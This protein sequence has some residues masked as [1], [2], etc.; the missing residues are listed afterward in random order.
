M[1]QTLSRPSAFIFP[2][3]LHDG[4][5]DA[6]AHARAQGACQ[7][8]PI[9]L[10]LIR[11]HLAENLCRGTCTLVRLACSVGGGK[12]EESESERERAGTEEGETRERGSEGE[13]VGYLRRVASAEAGSSQFR[14]DVSL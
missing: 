5:N 6:S 3:Y 11:R 7:R 9:L 10:A 14:I 2:R 8:L 13:S 4:F 12:V 1:S